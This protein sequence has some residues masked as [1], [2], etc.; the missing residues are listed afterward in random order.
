LLA[1]LGVH[2]ILHVSRIRVNVEKYGGVGQITE[3]NIILCMCFACWITKATD[4]HPEYVILIAHSDNRYANVP[5][6]YVICTFACLVGFSVQR[7]KLEITQK[8]LYSTTETGIIPVDK[9]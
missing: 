1:L 5:Q 2:H 8:P 3:D 7:C 9:V 6:Y 4:T